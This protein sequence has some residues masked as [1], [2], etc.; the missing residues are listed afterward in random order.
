MFHGYII[1]GT[2]RTGS[3][4]LCNLLASTKKTGNPDSFY[5]RKFMPAWAQEWRLPDR[6]TMSERDF[7]IAYLNAA[8]AAGTGGTGIFGLRLMREN[9]DELSAILDQIFPQLPSDKARLEKAFGRILYIY[10]SRE[11]KLAQAISLVKAEQTGLWHIAP[12]GTEIERLSPP[13]EPHYDF[14]RINREVLEL[15]S[16]D[17]AWNSWFDAQG[18]DPLCVGYETLSASPAAVLIGICETLG[19]PPP[20]AHDIKPG[21]AKLADETSLDWMRRYRSDI[22]S[23]ARS[24]VE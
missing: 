10:L 14:A 22:G 4:L 21:V 6:D 7:N 24:Q 16:Y 1:C 5:G 20:N 11:D 3:T 15:E 9:L 8:V 17:R 18:I 12:D 13:Q 19:I 23:A 2:P